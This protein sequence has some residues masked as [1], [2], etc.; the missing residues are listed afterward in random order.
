MNVAIFGGTGYVGG[1]LVD[2]LLRAGHGVSVLVRRG[3]EGKLRNATEC[4]LVAGDL[5]DKGAIRATVEGCAAVIYNVGLLR[6]F[7]SQGITFEEAH[8]AGVRR[9]AE[10]AANAG[11]RRFILM[12]ANGVRSGGTP[13]QD[14]KFRAERLVKEAGFEVTIFRPSVI[15]GDPR[16]TMEIATQLYADLVRPPVP[17]AGFHTGWSP[18]RGPVMMSPVHVEDVADA[19]VKAL[20]DKSTHGKTIALGGPDALSWTEM[21]RRVAAAAGR[22]KLVLPMPIGLMKLGAA[23]LDWLPFFPV[24]RDQLTMLEEGNTAPP[25]DLEGLIGRPARAFSAANLA[26]L[27]RG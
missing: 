11:I 12:S 1:Y 20:D 8:V 26:Y 15:F 19:F 10:A 6:E 3:S 14:T 4:R 18:A 24:T 22:R 17:A 27:E 2:A 21:L 23:L 13:Y 7:P 5:T 9:V 25:G 16:G